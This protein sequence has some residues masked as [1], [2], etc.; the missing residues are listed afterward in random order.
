MVGVS[1][2]PDVGEP[3][4]EHFACKLRFPHAG[5]VG[6]GGE[7]ILDLAEPD[8]PIGLLRPCEGAGHV[9][10]IIYLKR[11]I[12]IDIGVKIGVSRFDLK[13]AGIAFGKRL[14]ALQCILCGMR[15]AVGLD[16]T[17]EHLGYGVVRT[18]LR[19][20]HADQAVRRARSARRKGER[21]GNRKERD[22]FGGVGA[23]KMRRVLRT[24]QRAAADKIG[25]ARRIFVHEFP[26][27]EKQGEALVRLQ[28]FRM[29]IRREDRR[30]P[31][32]FPDSAFP[33]HACVKDVVHSGFRRRKPEHAGKDD[34][35]LPL[36]VRPVSDGHM[37]HLDRLRHSFFLRE[38]EDRTFDAEPALRFIG[39]YGMVLRMAAD[40]GPDIRFRIGGIKNDL[41][42]FDKIELPIA[43]LAV[44]LRNQ[45]VACGSDLS[46]RRRAEGAASERI[47]RALGRCEK[48]RRK[49]DTVA[50]KKIDIEMRADLI[51]L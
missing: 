16:K 51:R 21:L 44:F 9:G 1:H 23:G 24:V 12:S 13:I 25:I 38:N 14:D 32:D 49:A 43:G 7:H 17:G 48:R 6:Q 40:G 37:L 20:G 47:E 19:D 30:Y 2:F 8:F 35:D 28:I 18:I 45:I 15:H 29:R 4:A 3:F 46:C 22:D 42:V 41:S 33:C 27:A 39:N 36:A 34:L 11:Q 26:F 10:L 31:V 50:D 5:D